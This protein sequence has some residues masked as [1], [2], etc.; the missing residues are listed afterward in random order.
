VL[1]VRRDHPGPDPDVY[2]ANVT[3]DIVNPGQ[4]YAAFA[5][6]FIDEDTDPGFFFVPPD[7]PGWRHEL[8]NR[9]LVYS[10]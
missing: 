7:P 4:P 6:N 3:L 2:E 5:T 9:Y 8:P 1:R 10:K